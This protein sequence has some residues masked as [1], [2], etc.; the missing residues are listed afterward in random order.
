MLEI[1]DGQQVRRVLATILEEK[2]SSGKGEIES[3]KLGSYNLKS[4][5][6]ELLFSDSKTGD[7]QRSRG[8][9]SGETHYLIHREG[10]E[11]L[12]LTAS[13]EVLARMALMRGR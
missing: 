1:T 5:S 3:R 7:K 10:K 4:A 13:G 9:A 6:G 12:S 11:C 2:D 8:I